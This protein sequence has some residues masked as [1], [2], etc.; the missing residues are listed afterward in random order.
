MEKLAREIP[1]APRACAVAAIAHRG[2]ARSGIR[3]VAVASAVASPIESRCAYAGAVI[4]QPFFA[5]SLEVVS[6]YVSVVGPPSA[7]PELSTAGL[8]AVVALGSEMTTEQICPCC[9]AAMYQLPGRP[10]SSIR[11]VFLHLYPPYSHTFRK[12]TRERENEANIPYPD[13]ESNTNPS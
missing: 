12:E 4:R 5:A 1:R 8:L 6:R 13:L 7:S 11:V 3:C 2:I 9:A 10:S